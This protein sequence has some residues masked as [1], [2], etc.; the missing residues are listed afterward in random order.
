MAQMPTSEC[1][2]LGVA[3][4]TRSTALSSKALR[5][6]ATHLRLAALLL[7]DRL[8]P[9][10]ADLLVG[11]DDVEHLGVLAAGV[12]AQVA[13][14]LP[15]AADHGHAQLLVGAAALL[16]A[17]QGAGHRHGRRRGCGQ[18]RILQE[19]TTRETGHQ[20]CSLE[21]VRGGRLR[22]EC[23]TEPYQSSQ[24]AGVLPGLRISSCSV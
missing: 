20:R 14:P 11:I 19:T 3:V 5:M 17:G 22:K 6:S 21:T 15:A 2:W 7:G 12:G 18:Q 23:G 24:T 9:L 8:D 4:E 16:L 1:Q 10:L 13:A